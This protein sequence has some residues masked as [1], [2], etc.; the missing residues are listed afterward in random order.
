MQ[1]LKPAQRSRLSPAAPATSL[2][3][4]MTALLLSAVAAGA[5]AVEHGFHSEAA[6]EYW[7][8]FIQI[9]LSWI[10]LLTAGE[11]ALLRRPS[12]RWRSAWG[13][14]GEA[15]VLTGIAVESVGFPAG[16]ELCASAVFVLLACLANSQLARRMSRPTLLFPASFLALIAITTFL[17][18]L[19]AAT[20]PDRGIGWIDAAF[21][22]TSAVCVTGLI[23]RD[24][25]SGFTPFGQTVIAIAIQLGGLGV[26]IFGSTLVMLFGSRLSIRENATLSS[27][28]DEYPPAR[29]ARF[30]WFV[31]IATLALEI[32]V[33]A[34][35]YGIWP[36]GESLSV[37]Q[38]IGQ[39]M[40]HSVSA[41]CN[42]GFDITGESFVGMRWHPAVFVGIVPLIIMGGLGFVV[43]EE[44]WN[45]T[46]SRFKGDRRPVRLSTHARLVLV[47]TGLVLAIGAAV[48]FVAQ[49]KHPSEGLVHRLLDAAF[50]SVTARTAGFN[51]VPM[52]ELAPG[53]RFTLMVLML[54]GGSPG[55]T[56]GGTKTTVVAL[57]LLSVLS[58][59]RGRDETEVFR[60]ALPDPL[61]KRA[62]TVAFGMAAL[63][64]ITVLVLDMTESVAFEALFFEAISAATTTGL[65]LGATAEL[66]PMGRCIVI[67]T[68]FL[69]RVGPLVVAAS[70][71]IGRRT[72]S[73][74]YR[75]P[76]DSVSLG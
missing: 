59:L 57:L 72:A 18:K 2:W 25:S 50:M 61:V 36:N 65:S 44:C 19:P 69:G 28:L 35:M 16:A 8:D 42:A 73:G 23:V 64:S 52:D 56:A 62:A 29:I 63:V 20:P 26:M 55:G 46:R 33:A 71:V 66:T 58:T 40:F 76:R 39:A 49:L 1:D 12:G 67:A 70:L 15:S 74:S 53:S 54:V 37:M 17:L 75:Y 10:A 32:S 51:T 41:F 7:F 30:V 11:I 68:M 47:T 5:I 22:A 4:S 3:Q 48:I 27:V 31:V 60:R 9:G 24:T 13:L 45:W 43:L 21:T 6:P 34:M 38:R 14:A